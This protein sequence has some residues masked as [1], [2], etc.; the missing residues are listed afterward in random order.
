M[1]K[2]DFGIKL[3]YFVEAREETGFV[4]E[5]TS[6][7]LS[8]KVKKHY[9][10]N[11]CL[12]STLYRDCFFTTNSVHKK[13]DFIDQLNRSGGGGLTLSL[14][15]SELTDFYHYLCKA[16]NFEDKSNRKVGASFIGLQ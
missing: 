3:K 9:Q 5:V 6:S 15:D 1:P 16:F 11:K 13:S 10:A 7:H 14:R 2:S 12:M 4:A 8:E